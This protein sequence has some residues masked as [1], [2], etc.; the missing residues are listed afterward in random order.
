MT[1]CKGRDTVAV[2]PA[3]GS[4]ATIVIFGS[5]PVSL[6]SMIDELKALSSLPKDTSKGVSLKGVQVKEESGD[7]G[8]YGG[9][10]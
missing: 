1:A 7:S 4:D 2:S 9:G 3:L 8:T 6:S 5:E 10:S